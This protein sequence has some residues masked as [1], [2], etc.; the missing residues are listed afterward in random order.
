ME[1]EHIIGGLLRKRADIA[2]EIAVAHDQ[3]RALHADLA[4]VEA[5]LR[6]F[7][8]EIDFSGA[9]VSRKPGPLAA[10]YGEMSKGVRN[11]LRESLEP[12]TVTQVADIVIQAQGL[13]GADRMT[14]KKRVASA[15]RNLK[16]RGQAE[17]RHGVGLELVW[18]LSD[19]ASCPMATNQCPESGPGS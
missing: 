11:A 13:D 8:P 12:L 7:Q 5:T 9:R 18:R 2:G 14:V 6:M 16:T 3:L 4:H 17:S 15:L 10:G 19:P 1:N